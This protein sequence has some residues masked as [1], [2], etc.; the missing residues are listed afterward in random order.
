MAID[1]IGQDTYKGLGIPLFG[2]SVIR[3]R[4]SSNAILSLVHASANTGSFFQCMNYSSYYDDQTPSS[5]ITDL[6]LFDIDAAGGARGLSGST[7]IMELNSSGLYMGSTLVLELEDGILDAPR[8][9]E[10]AVISSGTTALTLTSADSGKLVVVSRNVSGASS[11]TVFITL[12]G[13]PAVG[14][15]YEVFANTTAADL[16]NV[17][18]AVTGNAQGFLIYDSTGDFLSTASV[19]CGTSGPMHF[20]FT[21]IS[22]GSLWVVASLSAFHNSSNWT[23]LTKAGSTSS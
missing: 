17:K 3:Q 1:P 6:V 9:R 20:R 11:N 2:E 14:D 10:T 19:T 21:A 16:V 23:G 5:V 18:T 13:T 8:Y 7:V 15:N 12:P 4:N 22:S